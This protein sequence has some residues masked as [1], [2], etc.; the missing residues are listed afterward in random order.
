MNP[1]TKL[2][3]NP[4]QVVVWLFSVLRIVI[5][6]HFLYE[7]VAKIIAGN[8]SSAGYLAGSRWIFAPLFHSMAGSPGVVS[9]V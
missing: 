4:N 6:W 9:G 7:G 8:W 1:E 2:N 5:G 3:S